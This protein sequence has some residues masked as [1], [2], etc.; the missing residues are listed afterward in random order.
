[1]LIADGRFEK[2]DIPGAL[3]NANQGQ[4]PDKVFISRDRTQDVLAAVTARPGTPPDLQ[5]FVP[6]TSLRG[7]FRAQG[8]RILRSLLP[9]SRPELICDP[10]EQ[11]NA[12]R[13]SCSK[14]LETN[15]QK[16]PYK[17]ACLACR[18]FGCT[19]T[20]SRIAFTDGVI[21]QGCSSVYRDMIGIDRFSGGVAKGANMRFHCLEGAAWTTNI[22]VTNFEL[23]HLG[24]LAYLFRDFAEERVPIGFGKTKGFGLVRGE[25]QGVELI[26]PANAGG[27]SLHHMGSLVEEATRSAYDMQEVQA[28]TDVSL[29]QV[30]DNDPLAALRRRFRVNDLDL[31]WRA[32]AAAFN[33]FVEA[34]QPVQ[35]GAP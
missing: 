16:P 33:A 9:E 22:T 11:D 17:H 18:L 34:K 8:E 5:F 28:P 6:G 27:E 30:Q 14:R 15:S 23:W 4:F 2:D 26:Y 21:E 3:R 19:H 31:L 24:L 35:E 29:A 32:A 13:L 12:A 20:A 7:P 1:L 10:F 25:V